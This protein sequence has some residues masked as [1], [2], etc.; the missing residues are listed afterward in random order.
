MLYNTYNIRISTFAKM[1]IKSIIISGIPIKYT[2]GFI[3]EL[4][5]NRKIA[6]I[7]SISSLSYVDGEHVYRRSYITIERFRDYEEA[8]CFIESLND[9]TTPTCIQISWTEHWQVHINHNNLDPDCL[10][11]T[12]TFPDSFFQRIEDGDDEEAECKL[13][14]QDQDKVIKDNITGIKYT[15]DEAI[16]RCQQIL[17][18]LDS[19]TSPGDNI[20]EQKDLCE[21]LDFLEKKLRDYG[22]TRISRGEK[23]IKDFHKPGLYMTVK[24]A[25]VRIAFLKGFIGSFRNTAFS[26]SISASQPMIDEIDFLEDQ[27]ISM[28]TLK[29]QNVTLRPHQEALV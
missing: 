24:E 22:N 13:G 16:E 3:A 29:S 7:K 15:A 18:L 14:C 12:T 20:D 6:Q 8:Y 11:F 25:N 23:L 27:I 19:H 1:D 5:W 21:E 26:M 28:V 9:K 10:Y 4:F 17:K 2:H